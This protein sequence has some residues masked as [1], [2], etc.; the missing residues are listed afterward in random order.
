LCESARRQRRQAF[1][2]G[3]ACRAFEEVSRR[4]RIAALQRNQAKVVVGQR[5]HGRCLRDL[6]E[7]DSGALLV[8]AAI[9]SDANVVVDRGA[10]HAKRQA[11]FEQLQG[12]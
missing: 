12:A 6:D 9:S 5:R 7:C 2:G 11:L 8:V 10:L 3:F 1:I 4:L